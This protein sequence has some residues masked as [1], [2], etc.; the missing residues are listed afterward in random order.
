MPKHAKKIL[1]ATALVVV[2][3]AAGAVLWLSNPGHYQAVLEE[4]VASATGYE[5]RVAGG[6]ELDLLPSAR[7]VLADVRLRNPA[8]TRELA[9]AAR[10]ELDVDRSGLPRGELTISEVRI[11]G[12]HINAHIDAAGNSIWTTGKT[13]ASGAGAAG[14]IRAGPGLPRRISA[15]GGRLDYQNARRGLRQQLKNI[16]LVVERPDPQAESFEALADFSL[17]WFDRAGGRLREELMVW[18]GQ[19]ETDGESGEISGDSISLSFSSMVLAG[20]FKIAGLPDD[21]RYEAQLASN[22]FDAREPLRRLGWLPDWESTPMSVPDG[23]PNGQ[24]PAAVELGLAGDARGLSATAIV[25]GSD[26]PLV[27]AETE[28][29]FANGS[30]PGYVRYQIDIG[31]IDISAWL[32]ARAAAGEAAGSAI[33]RSQARNP[34]RNRAQTPVRRQSGR[35]LPAMEGLNLSG[36]ITA[37]A[38]AAGALRV[39]NLTAYTNVESRVFDL[40]IPPVAALGGNFSANLRW[41]AASGELSSEFRGG[42]LAIAE[43]APLVTRLDVLTG[44]LQ[45]DGAFTANGHS[46]SSLLDD[47]R[48]EATFS[49]TENLVNIGLIKQIFTSI[50]ALSPSGEAIQRWPDLI[51]FNEVGG[52]LALNGGLGSEHAFTLRMDNLSAAGAGIADLRGGRFDYDMRLTLLGEPH[53]QTIPVGGNYQGLDWPVECA[54]SFADEVAQFCR[55]DF[56]AAREI[57]TGIGADAGGN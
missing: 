29:R 3:V 5:L 28:V 32:A 22:G 14:N 31:E 8:S 23:G 15:T 55:P 49:V 18:S 40:E 24:W 48:G 34:M 25:T 50:S 39:E 19:I 43:I 42:E 45:V 21:P 44:R 11:D 2:A 7:L 38:L 13:A 12:F 57:F 16:G 1:A 52:S 10:I 26:Q 9:S 6:V 41:N 54:A 35:S 4:R 20:Q 46:A 36:S 33:W 30:A 53:T 37:A 47:L 56:N 51:R 27:E 17:E